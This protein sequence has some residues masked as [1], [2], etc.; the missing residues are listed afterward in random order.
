MPGT[1]RITGTERIGWS[2]QAANT[3]ELASFRYVIYVDAVANDAQGVSCSADAGPAGYAC[4]GRLPSMTAGPHALTLSSFIENG[5]A[6]LESPRS[7]A[8]TVIL[9]SQ[10][11]S[12]AS[13]SGDTTIVTTLDGVRLR[14]QVVVDGL[15]EPTDLAFAP[16]GRIFIAERAGRIRVVRGGRQAPRPALALAD[17]FTDGGHGLLALAVD[18]GYTRNRFVYLV[19]TTPRGFRL[20]RV[21]G[22]GDTLG[23]RA[24]LLD[25]IA[26]S[27]PRPSA[28]LRFGPDTRLYLAL[29]DA[30]DVR[31][32]GDLGSFNGKLLRLNADATTPADQPSASPVFVRGLGA[33]RGVA[34]GVDGSTVW[35]LDGAG[36]PGGL[37]QAASQ[38]GTVVSRYRLPDGASPSGVAMYRG[39]LIPAF[40]GNLLLGGSGDGSLLRLTLDPADPTKVAAIERLRFTSFDEVRTLT[41]GPDGAVY[42]CTAR[43]LLKLSPSQ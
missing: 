38:A 28:A 5:G 3:E 9:L 43:T 14:S 13:G 23:D 17:V 22:V 19:Y 31:R 16:D 25:D 24:I 37:L 26:A 39:D 41:V 33:P 18:P 36:A 40:R 35:V 7:A 2:Q 8:I 32:Q 42:V 1:E 6:R 20:A 29:D 10:S 12:A 30:G 4:T 27:A 11:T 34:W 21:R 15:D